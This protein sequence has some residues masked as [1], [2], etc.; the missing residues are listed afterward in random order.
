[1]RDMTPAIA[2]DFIRVRGARVHNL[3]AVDVDVPRGRLV[4]ISGV[5]GSG[6]TS[7]A[8]DTLFAE[9]QRRYLES[10]STYARR[11]LGRMPSALVDQIRGL[12]PTIAID[13]KSASSN[14][15]STVATIT[16]VHDYLR[17]LYARIGKPH[18]PVCG[19][20]LA[21]TS[22]SRLAGELLRSEP[23]GRALILAP[24]SLGDG[25]RVADGSGLI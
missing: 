15:R 24:M 20:P 25:T 4:V 22:P 1:M 17:L 7:L 16:E 23:G 8:F 19:N 13:Q 5:S 12:S 3:R 21:W 11:F 14:P 18:C 9:G 10:L 6:K 2:T